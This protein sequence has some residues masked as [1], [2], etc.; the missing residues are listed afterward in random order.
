LAGFLTGKNAASPKMDL[1]PIR[2]PLDE[3]TKLIAMICTTNSDKEVFRV[4]EATLTKLKK[5]YIDPNDKTLEIKYN[6]DKKIIIYRSFLKKSQSFLR[7]KRYSVRPDGN[8]GSKTEKAFSKFKK[9]NNIA[10]PPIPDAFFVMAL[11][12]NK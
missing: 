5:Y 1:F 9:D 7:S 11:I 2:G 6:D 3:W 4:A 10:G 8:W 12:A